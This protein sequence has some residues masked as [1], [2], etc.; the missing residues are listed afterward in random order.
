MTA[1]LGIFA[2]TFPRPTAAE[3]AAEV[4]AHGFELTQLNLS[5]M[6]LPTLPDVGDDVDYGA[7]ADAFDREHVTIW[8]LS[9]TFNAIHPDVAFRAAETAK[10]VALLTT[11][12]A[13]RYTA[14]TLCT[15]TRNPD[16][17]WRA[18]PDN[19]NRQAWTDLR[20]T[21]DELIPAAR[22]AGVRLGVEPEPGNV[23]A[24]ARAAE[25]LLSQ[26][27]GDAEVIGIVLDPANLLSPGT[28]PQQRAILSAAFDNL[29][30]HTICV[31][32]KDVVEAG[33]Y[34]AAGRGGLD[35][36]LVLQLHAALPHAVPIVIQDAAEDD[37]ERTRTFLLDGLARR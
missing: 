32:A 7:I 4:A 26:L 19:S 30:E 10:A 12:G 21:L 37:V 36:D 16:D 20:A 9:A 18:H 13:L 24:D 1:R 34:A 17:M 28:L 6:G 2:R 11:T 35:Y 8:G 3:V 22:T 15:G 31:H 29:G 14:A 27:G 33:Q 25:R 5:S 23:I